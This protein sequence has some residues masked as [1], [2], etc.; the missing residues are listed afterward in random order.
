MAKAVARLPG[1]KGDEAHVAV[2]HLG[3]SHRTG[4]RPPAN[5]IACAK[6]AAR[7]GGRRRRTGARLV[8]AGDP[9]GV[10]DLLCRRSP[11]EKGE[12]GCPL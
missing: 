4:T 8:V 1:S 3:S 2:E 12:L 7:S 9:V 11:E 5:G 6:P 10:G